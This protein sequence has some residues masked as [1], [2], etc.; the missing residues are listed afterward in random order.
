MDALLEWL[1][2]PENPPARY[3]AA[4]DLL[5]RTQNELAALRRD[6]L[7]WPPLQDMLNLQREDGGFESLEK[8]QT[9]RATFWA[10][11]LMARCGLEADDEPVSRAIGYLEA[12]HHH[13]ALSYSGGA[14]GVLPCYQ[15][16]TV[17]ALIRLG[18]LDT[19]LVRDSLRWLVDHQRFDHRNSRHGGTAEWPYRAPANFGCWESVS[20]YHGVAGAFRALA[21][22]PPGDRTPEIEQRLEEALE[23]L[24]IHRLYKKSSSGQPLFR[25]M[26][27]FSLVADY[28]SDLLDMLGGIA[29]A[30]PSLGSEPW[31]RDAVQDMDDSTVDGKV[32]LVKNYG[33]KLMDPIPFEPIGKPSR[34][35]TLEWMRV[36]RTLTGTG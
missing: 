25:H 15:G 19:A 30:D 2:S 7:D 11:R 18:A 1:S 14:A 27:Q 20:C 31:V 36:R 12:N 6:V 22:V 8:P 35:L 16:V 21:A 3:Q 23:Y 26:T 29:A 28:R 33:K 32:M 10:L 4:R 24:R 13:Q 5:G 34:L 17:E 9:A